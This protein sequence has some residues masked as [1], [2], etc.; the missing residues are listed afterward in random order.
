[1]VRQVHAWVAWA[2]VVAIVTQVFLAGLSIAQ[3]GGT[4]S[5]VTHVDVGRIFGIAFLALVITAVAARTGRRRILQAAGLLGLFVV[6]SIL[7]YL[8]P[9]LPFAAALHPVNALLMFG[10]A[11]AYAR[12]AWRERLMPATA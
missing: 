2:V 6:Q 9:A 10:L 7:P 4:G 5:F 8:D 11:V 3:L 12:A 1:M